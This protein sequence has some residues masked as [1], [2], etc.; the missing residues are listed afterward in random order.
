MFRLLFVRCL[1]QAFQWL[2]VVL[3]RNWSNLEESKRLYRLVLRPYVQRSIE[4]LGLPHG[5]T[6]FCDH[7]VEMFKRAEKSRMSYL[8]S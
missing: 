8:I 1:Q 7:Q 2:A 6:A 4:D 5:K 3:C